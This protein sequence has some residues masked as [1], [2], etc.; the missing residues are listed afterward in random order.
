MKT[1][2][3][4][5]LGVVSAEHAAIAA[6]EGWIQLNHGKRTNLARLSQGDGFVIYSSKQ[7]MTDTKPLKMITQVGIV[8]DE[9][10]FLAEQ[11]MSMGARGTIQ[12]W[13]RKVDFAQITPVPIADLELELTSAPN[14]GYALRYGMVPLTPEDFAVIQKATS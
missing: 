5:W 3:E 11:P 6:A 9:E 14:W 12:P 8:A 1:P 7:K 2:T 10:P 13:R 4:A